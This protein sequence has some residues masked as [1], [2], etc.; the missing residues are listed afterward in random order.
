MPPPARRRFRVAALLLVGLVLR[1][2]AAASDLPVAGALAAV[3]RADSRPVAIRVQWGG[4]KPRAWTGAIAVT[5]AGAAA[6]PEWRT[7]CTEPDAAALLHDSG[8]E[9]T[10][11]QP[12]PIAADGVEL[13]IAE[14][15]TARLRVRL[16][17]A[18][19]G[20]PETV[21]E[22]AVAD[23]LA[24]AVQQQLDGDGNRLTIRQATGDPLR[25]VIADP[26]AAAGRAAV[27]RPGE[28][29][30]LRVD[31]LLPVRAD[32]SSRFE[33]RVRLLAGPKGEPHDAQAV[34]IVPRD[35]AADAAGDRR[36]TR[37]EPVEFEIA[38]PDREGGCDVDLQVVEVGSLR[39]SRTLAGRTVQ[40]VA[41]RDTPP[42]QSTGGW[43]LVHEVDPGSPRLHERLRR[44]PGTGLGMPA[45]PL[46]AVPLPAFP[47][48]TMTLPNVQLPSVQLPNVPLPKM[49]SVGL[50]P[51]ASMVPRF[52]GLLVAGHST[53]EP[54]ALGLMLLLPPAK[55]AGEPA[56]EG[57][58]LAGAQP[59]VPHAVEIE[60]PSDQDA[61][62]GAAV[63]EL[64]ATAATV[65]VRHAGGFEVRRDAY[66]PQP[67]LRRH[68]F[69]FWPTTR[70]PLVVVSNP[71]TRRSA[72]VGKVRIFS[73]PDRLPAAE[74]GGGTGPRRTFAILPTPDFAF[75]GGVE[76]VDAA[77]GRGAADWDTH[78]AAVRHSAEWL[79]SRAAA[80]GLVTVYAQGAA[81]WPSPLTR[82]APRWGSG[83]A[84]D[85]G[86]D[87]QPKDVL[88]LVCR[89][90]AAEGL[91][92]VPGMAFDGPLPELEAALAA[93]GDTATG[94]ACVGRDGRP[95]RT[96]HGV[97]YNVLDPRVQRAVERQVRELAGRVR[98]CG[99]VEG[100]A[101]LLSHEGWLHLP[102]AAAA[103]DD[104]TFK[105]FLDSVNAREPDTGPDRFAGR[106]AMVEGRLRDLWLEWRADVVAAF[107]QRLA[108]TVVEH[109]PRLALHIVPTTLFA[110]GDLATRFRPRLGVEPAAVDA[111]REAGLDPLRSTAHPQVVFA[112]PHVHTAAD[113]LVD[114]GTVAAAN[115]APTLAEAARA[116][117]RRSIAII[118]QPV[119]CDVRPIAAHGPFG[120][121]TPTGDLPLHAVPTG[122]AADR[123]LAEALVA[124]DAEVVFDMRLVVGEVAAPSRAFAALPGGTLETVT[125]LPFPV[126]IRLQR[127]AGT[128][129]MRVVNAAAAPGVIRIG[130]D[131][132]PAAVVDAVDRSRLEI[133]PDGVATVPVGA[134]G[135][136]TLLVDGDVTVRSA[137]IDY[138]AAVQAAVAARVQDLRRRRAA[139]EMPTPLEV[140]DNPGFDVG[141]E[142]AATFTDRAGGRPAAVTGWEL[143][144]QRRG[145]LELV[146]GRPAGT[147]GPGRGLAFASANGLASLHSNP[148]P[149]PATGRVSVGCWLRLQDGGG[150]PPLRIALEGVHEDREYYRFAPVGGLAGG[151]PLTGEWAQFVLPVDDLPTAGVESLRVRFDLLG[152][153]A[154]MIDD[155]GVYDLAFEESQRV[156]L[157]RMIDRFDQALATRDV[158]G[159]VVGLDGHWPRFLAEFI[160]DAAVAR[161]AAV[162]AP[163]G[164]GPPTPDKPAAPGTMRDRVKGWWR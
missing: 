153:G 99:A 97:H 31:P 16:A 90:Y 34:P 152:P 6:V 53:V 122:S 2:S 35:V 156:Q 64:D 109:D 131:G 113:G 93:G 159:C 124:A 44:L 79:A 145:T 23:V 32:Q 112:S 146:A 108:A 4:G 59:G 132:R 71:S 91:K 67:E 15:R 38:L 43:K 150:Q 63:L 160:S 61:V 123:P 83:A 76:R 27:R 26:E 40:L 114:A 128:T 130:L 161:M 12:R 115:L 134:W 111:M 105:R 98:G 118:E 62:V 56:W 141:P 72:T 37:F 77:T 39:W 65:E 138:E 119:S 11:H 149:P 164:S 140:L 25:V 84:Q 151:R 129:W 9:I 22:V 68:R 49:P 36:L 95:L 143:V 110:A 103:L 46:P 120:N 8:T 42:P 51:M 7:L 73:G 17:A 75:W 48:P 3:A 142:D 1:G 78:L 29:V 94:I 85:T 139:L 50:P 106:A 88:D 20:Q 101:V 33:L 74:G 163:P 155:V 144:E 5:T 89:V 58:V 158:G 21:V 127:A 60:Y 24:A 96:P 162:P 57:I 137:R 87:P 14:W 55:A 107:H 148:F 82:H 125:G 116:A 102:G 133:A 100:V 41:V 47:R 135:V 104:A 92:L 86:L 80:G 19:G 136:R 69:V 54:H 157:A 18:S 10:V 126:V 52:S 70:H 147:G 13:S 28:R 117:R 154:V 81:A 121:A 45:L 30:R 66:G